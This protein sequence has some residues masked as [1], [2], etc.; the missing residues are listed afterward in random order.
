[1]SDKPN[2]LSQFWHELKR[3]RVIHVITVYASASFVLIELVNNLTDPLKLNSSLATIVIIVLEVG[4]P[5]AVILSWIYDLTGEGIEK[6]RSI[7][8][9]PDQQSIKVPTAWKVATYVSFVVIIALVTFNF[10]GGPRQLRSGDIQSLVILP[11]ENFTGDD[12]MENMVAGMH[13]LLIG[14]MGRVSGLRV[15]GKTSSATYK[16][17][18]MTA[19]DIAN[20][21]NVDAVLEATV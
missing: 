19:G 1:M 6:T 12:Q 3:R 2:K 5:L 8:E 18:E 20:E 9:E 11:F 15:I 16:Q 4:F 21:L 10:M 13:S 7:D 14:D 17:V